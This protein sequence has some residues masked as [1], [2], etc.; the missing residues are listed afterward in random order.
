[1]WVRSKDSGFFFFFLGE[2]SP[3]FDKEIEFFGDFLI[4]KVYIQINFLF[5]GGFIWL[6][7]NKK[8][9]KKC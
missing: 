5:F 2:F 9:K 3:F 7:F 1:M 8:M 4:K 6:N